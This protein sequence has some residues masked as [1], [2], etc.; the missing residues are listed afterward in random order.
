MEY[1]DFEKRRRLLIAQRNLK[2][3]KI[4]EIKM[5]EFTAKIDKEAEV[6]I[7]QT[8]LKLTF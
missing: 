5:K 8:F 1:Y 3:F 2:L 4:N 6:T 7:N